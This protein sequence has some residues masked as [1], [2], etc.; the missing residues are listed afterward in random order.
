MFD[1][2]EMTAEVGGCSSFGG[3]R[4]ES[5]CPLYPKR[6]ERVIRLVSLLRLVSDINQNVERLRFQ[7]GL[8]PPMLSLPDYF[9]TYCVCRI[10]AP[11]M[12]IHPA[13]KGGD[14]RHTSRVLYANNAARAQGVS[15]S[16]DK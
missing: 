8:Q 1:M 5:A 4:V 15:N 9:F 6:R 12:I 11:Q 3:T 13:S 14:A 2:E 7:S 10:P 16:I